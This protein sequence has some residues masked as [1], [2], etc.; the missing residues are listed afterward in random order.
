L[1]SAELCFDREELWFKRAGCRSQSERVSEDCEEISQRSERL[2]QDI[3]RVSKQ[4]ERLPL[5]L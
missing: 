5:K 3:E 4:S 1:L 2:S